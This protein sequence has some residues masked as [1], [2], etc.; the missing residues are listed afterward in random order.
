MSNSIV[1][2]FYAM[3]YGPAPEDPKEVEHWLD[4]H[5]RSF[6]LYINGAWQK[7][8][9]GEYFAT[10]NPATGDKIADVAQAEDRKSVV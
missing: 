3:T 5:N 4:A 9:S 2:E 10:S 6:D 1:E 7:S 8:V